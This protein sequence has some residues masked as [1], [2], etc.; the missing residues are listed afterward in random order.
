VNPDLPYT[1]SNSDSYL[2]TW[3]DIKGSKRYATR[4]SFFGRSVPEIHPE[5]IRFFGS[6]CISVVK[7]FS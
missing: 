7:P 1:E 5:E 2:P 3:R 4:V 6:N